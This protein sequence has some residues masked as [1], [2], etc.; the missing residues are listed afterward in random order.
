MISD[1]PGLHEQRLNG[2]D[3]KPHDCRCV[4]ESPTHS[5]PDEVLLPGMAVTEALAV[6]RNEALGVPE[7]GAVRA[8]PSGVIVVG[9]R[10]RGVRWCKGL[11]PCH[12][13]GDAGDLVV[14]E[15]RL[16]AFPICL[17]EGR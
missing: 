17:G 11:I 14:V 9:A 8:P 4:V 15:R 6:L 3:R 16:T 2:L 5:I 1:L 7:V 13:P 12:A 10:V